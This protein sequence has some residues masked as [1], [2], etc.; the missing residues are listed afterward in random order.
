M[1]ILAR[2][3]LIAVCGVG[4]AATQADDP[5]RYSDWSAPV[6]LGATVNSSAREAGPWISKDELSLYFGVQDRPGGYGGFD[7]WVSQRAS[8]YDTWGEPQNLGPN[9]NTPYNEQTPTLSLDEHSLYFVSDRP[10]GV[11]GF[12][13]YVSRRH[14]RRDDFA[15]R[16]PEILGGGVN[17]I[18]DEFGPS[19][20]EDDETGTIHLY[21]CSN[22]GGPSE[23]DIYESILQPDDTFGPPE[24]VNELNS[25]ARDRLD[26]RPCIRR[27][28]LEIFFD[29][30]RKEG[31]VGGNDLWVSTRRSIS[32]PWSTPVNLGPLINTKGVEV[33]PALS[34][35][36][37]S[38]YFHSG[39]RGGYGDYDLFVCTRTKLK[40]PDEDEK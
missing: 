25:S 36:G 26:A 29:S 2:L 11:G 14:N 19:F 18:Y 8:V 3:F 20:F 1:A 5:P 21:F 31:S 10:G 22:P 9:I 16:T 23:F 27:D 37:T 15:W 4:V 30:N 13:M 28:G 12:D 35:D 17:S 39:G 33:R 32:D 40:G 24:L 38:L 34:F 6:N 7:I